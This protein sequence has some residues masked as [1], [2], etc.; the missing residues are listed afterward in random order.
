MRKKAWFDSGRVSLFALMVFTG[1]FGLTGCGGGG[2]GAEDGDEAGDGADVVDDRADGTDA[3]SDAAET[4]D[5]PGDADEDGPGPDIIP[6]TP[7]DDPGGD[8]DAEDAVDMIETEDVTGPELPRG[9]AWVR[10][11]PMF[12]SGSTISM[13]APSAAAVNAY[14]DDFKANAVHLWEDGLPTEMDGWRAAGRDDMRFVSWVRDDGTSHDGGAV[15]GG[16]PAGAEGRIGYQISDEPRSMDDLY[17]IEAGVDAVRAADPDAL[18]IV[19]FSFEPD[20]IEE[21]LAY[22][23]ENVDGDVI[24]YDHYSRSNGAYW[25]MEMFRAY[26][27]DFG[28]PYWR[29]L[30]A[31]Q[32]MGESDWSSESDMRWNA[33]VGLVYGYTGHSWFIYQ[34]AP[35]HGLWSAF[36]EAA[37]DFGSAR[38]ARFD[39]AAQINVELANLGRSITQLTSTDVRYV[40][41]MEVLKPVGTTA[42]ERGAGGDWLITEITPLSGATVQDVL[43]GFFNDDAGEKYFMIQNVNHTNGDWPVS[44]DAASM[45]RVRFDFSAVTDPGFDRTILQSLNKTTGAVET[46]PLIHVSGDTYLLEVTLPAGDAILLKYSTGADFMGL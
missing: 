16:Y 12:I 9:L 10:S 46:I 21:M 24:A 1:F 19:N 25:T 32:V 17:E 26:A 13:G 5:V 7:G 15:I 4:T 6:D 22:Y 41:G 11:N 18:I 31:H 27:L 3:V 40:P 36:F 39:I 33:F 43:A 8:L 42:W 23:C 38:T 14:F 45:I 44:S 2:N 20:A 37:G 28:M 35:A 30:Y 29:Y 34:I